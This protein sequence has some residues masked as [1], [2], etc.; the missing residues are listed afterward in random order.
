[1]LVG[2]LVIAF[3]VSV[4]SDLWSYELHKKGIL[5]H[6]KTN[7]NEIKQVDSSQQ[8][9]TKARSNEDLSSNFEV[10]RVN[11]G[12]ELSTI[13]PRHL[14]N[15]TF[16]EEEEYRDTHMVDDTSNDPNLVEQNEKSIPNSGIILNES[17][18]EALSYHLDAIDEAQN[19]IYKSQHEISRRMIVINNSKKAIREIIGQRNKTKGVTC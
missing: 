4:F 1:M 12:F 10:V 5:S 14:T 15:L 16:N 6:S 8:H 18:F 7:D 19:I 2:L 11:E 3:P 17:D 9:M 13:Q